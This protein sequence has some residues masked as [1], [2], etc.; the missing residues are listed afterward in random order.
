M[1]LE[2]IRKFY[3]VPAK[4]GMRF[5]AWHMEYDGRNY[6]CGVITG[7]DPGGYVRV[8]ID[9]ERR[10]SRIFHPTW[11]TEYLDGSGNVIWSSELQEKK[12]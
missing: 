10:K 7:S 11:N 4:R 5:R 12:S 8:R 2:Y 1:S 9:G 6:R 3:G